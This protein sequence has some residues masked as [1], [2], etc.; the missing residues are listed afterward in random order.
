MFQLL[1]GIY[2]DRFIIFHVRMG[3]PDVAKHV[4]RLCVLFSNI[5]SDKHYKIKIWETNKHVTKPE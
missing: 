1:L 2:L 4:R 3:K 5:F